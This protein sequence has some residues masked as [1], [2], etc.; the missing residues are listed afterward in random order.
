MIGVL[1]VGSLTPRKFTAGDL[2]LLQL[3]AD[4]LMVRRQAGSEGDAVADGS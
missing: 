2:E 4:L 3:T 1:H